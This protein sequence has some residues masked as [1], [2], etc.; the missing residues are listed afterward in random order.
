MKTKFIYLMLTLTVLAS[1]AFSPATK[2]EIYVKEKAFATIV[3]LPAIDESKANPFESMS[4]E[5]KLVI[6]NKI[7]EGAMFRNTFKLI[8]DAYLY[9]FREGTPQLS[10]FGQSMEAF[11]PD[12]PSGCGVPVGVLDDGAW[13][14]CG[15]Y[16]CYVG[17]GP[18][19][20]STSICWGYSTCY[21]IA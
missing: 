5:D 13:Q 9:G 19:W 1:S 18:G 3:D 7:T 10:P 15:H 14:V 16:Y 17:Y 12:G 20:C 11:N 6:M 8:G 4:M 21:K 2:D